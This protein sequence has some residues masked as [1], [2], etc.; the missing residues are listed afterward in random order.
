MYVISF[1]SMD[2]CLN[3]NDQSSAEI[4]SNYFTIE[5]FNSRF[6]PTSTSNAEQNPKSRRRKIVSPQQISDN[7][8]TFGLL[9]INARS[10]KKTRR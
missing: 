6:S 8:H 5:E 1:Y 3:D 2:P 7:K 4:Q 10:L 9:H